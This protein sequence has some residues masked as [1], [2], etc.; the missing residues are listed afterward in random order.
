MPEPDDSSSAPPER[1]PDERAA[2]SIPLGFGGV[3]AAAGDHIAHFYRGADQRFSVLGPYIATGL[4]RGDRCI[5]ISSPDVADDLRD[6]L[7][8]RDL[9]AGKAE[10]DGRLILHPGKATKEDMQDLAA[11]VHDEAHAAGHPFVR[12]AG[13]GGWALADKMSVHDMLHW[14]AL[15][16]KCSTDWDI[17]ALCQ[18]DQT[19][20]SGNVLMDA[21]RSHPYCVMGQVV[22]PNPFH[23][24]PDALLEEL[25]ET[26][27]EAHAASQ[28]CNLP[29]ST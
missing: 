28:A 21:L 5:V 2:D 15:Y 1:A 20:F 14:E 9:D 27:H 17:L 10:A 18:F 6:W 23:T 11:R 16:D 12:W 4:Q 22:V 29:D 19:M 13:D 24:A 8:A 3:S 25:S 26:D 7:A